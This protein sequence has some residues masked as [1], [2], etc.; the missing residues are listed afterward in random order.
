MLIFDE[1]QHFENLG[2]NGFEKYPNKRDLT[3]LCSGWISQG[4]QIK[5]LKFLMS[6]FCKQ[7]NIK[8][9]YAKN[10]NLL[11]SVVDSF[12]NNENN[13][14]RAH[15]NNRILIYNSEIEIIKQLSGK[16]NQKVAFAILCLAK[17]RNSNYIYLN[18]S[19]SIHLKDVFSLVG[20]KDTNK[21][22]NLILHSLNEQG[23]LDVQLKPIMKCFIPCIVKE[24]EKFL[25]FEISEENVKKN[26][27]EIIG[28]KCEYCGN[29]FE[30]IKN[31][32]K[33]CAECGKKMNII[34]TLER[35]R[36]TVV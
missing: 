32:Q 24:G 33:Y 25:D 12:K 23:F 18:D 1:K 11:L 35:R 28:C 8:F 27:L 14:I 30:R 21:N 17:W 13:K 9:N 26:L 16:K 7:W 6:N 22:M 3:C 4:A 34:K 19:S 31:N 2:K 20:L 5:D 10:E 15:I 29:L 36:R